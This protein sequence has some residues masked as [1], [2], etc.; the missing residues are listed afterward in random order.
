MRKVLTS[1]FLSGLLFSGF[2]AQEKIN[3]FEKQIGQDIKALNENINKLYRLH[4][5]ECA[6]QEI[7]KAEA[8]VDALDGLS[9]INP[10]TGE[11]VKVQVKTIDKIIYKNKAKKYI[12]IAREKVYADQDGDGIPCYQ[13]IEQGTNPFVPEGKVSKTE[14]RKK[15]K[16]QEISKVK[17]GYKP[18]KMHARIHFDFDKFNIKKDYLPYLNVITRYLK[19][20]KDLKIKIVGYTDSI[21]SKEYND[22]LARKRAEAI[23]KYLIDH[24]ISPDRIE[25]IGKGK[26][27]YLFDNSTSLNRFTNRRA[28]FFVMEP[29]ENR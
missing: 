3:L 4:V 24:G 11:I 19:A 1:V 7:A 12:S 5:R 2:T 16:V 27:D 10:D 25:I 6:P 14:T 28:E 22:R 20:H 23:R 21:G 15:Q 8:Y 13:E 26:E 17:T 9:Y 18:L 29:T